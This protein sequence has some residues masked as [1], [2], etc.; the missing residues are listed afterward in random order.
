MCVCLPRNTCGDK[1]ATVDSAAN[2]KQRCWKTWKKDGG[3]EEYQAKRL[4][5]H[6]AYL[7]SQAKQEVPKDPSHSSSDFSVSPTKLRRENLDVEGEKPIRNDTGELRLDDRAMQAAW[8]EHYKY[9]LLMHC[10]KIKSPANF[11]EW[12][13]C[14]SGWIYFYSIYMP[15][16][17]SKESTCLW[18][19]W[20]ENSISLIIT[21]IS[22][23]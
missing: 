13:I 3:K 21:I 9:S 6:A 2:N 16:C 22:M 7:K 14:F 10:I 5:K 17:S 23:N 11:F 8:K 19:E 4:A 20:F 15:S 18:F 12:A 1:N